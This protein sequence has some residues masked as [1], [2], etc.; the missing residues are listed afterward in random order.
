MDIYGAYLG[1]FGVPVG[2]VSGEDISVEQALKTIPWAR[3]VVVD[4]HKE[5]YTSGEQSI[6]YLAEGRER[7]REQAMKAVQDASRMKPLVVP[8]PLHFEAVFRD[9]KL[10]NKFNTWG[11]DQ[12][13]E[14]VSW[15]ANN[16]IE[17][18]EKLN[19]L[20]FFPKNIY[21][22]RRPM[23]FLM[24]KFYFI[25]NTYFAPTTNSEGASFEKR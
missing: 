12:T 2:F 3:S 10:A 8:G 4:K 22:L 18:F 11:F 20:T 17:G 19:K 7:L 24:R 9:E 23:L 6:K 1:E 16:M 5:A 21:P 15:D 14:T 25:K 13:R